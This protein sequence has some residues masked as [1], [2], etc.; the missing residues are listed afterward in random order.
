M[1]I[2]TYVSK[3]ETFAPLLDVA[4]GLFA[5]DGGWRKSFVEQIALRAH[6]IVV[7]IGCGDG[8][9]ALMLAQAAP[10]A[11]IIGIDPDPLALERARDRAAKANARITFIQELGRNADQA[12]PYIAP[13]K[14]VSSLMLHKVSTVEKRETLAAARRA[15]SP[16]GVLHVADYGAQRTLL[17]QRLFRTLQAL[18]GF[19]HTDAHARGALPAMI[20]TASFEAVEETMSVPTVQGSISFYRARAV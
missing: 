4:V 20:R 13:T 15:L 5:R 7:D 19:E 12:I 9:L 18:E 17:M 2:Q 14:V 6:D 8:S 10:R 1:S 16:G 3:E 11:T